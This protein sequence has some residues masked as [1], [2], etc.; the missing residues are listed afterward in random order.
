MTQPQEMFFQFIMQHVKEDSR[1]QARALLDEAFAKQQEG[2]MD[3]LYLLGFLPRMLACIKPESVE[4]V[5]QVMTNFK[6]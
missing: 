4:Q 3:K 2:S 1:D 6:P 5:K